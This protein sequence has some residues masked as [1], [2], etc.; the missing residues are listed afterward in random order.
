MQFQLERDRQQ[1]SHT[2][3]DP[4]TAPKYSGYKVEEPHEEIITRWGP[5]VVTEGNWV[6]T[7]PLGETFGVANEDVE[8]SGVWVEAEEQ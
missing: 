6:F 5:T 2:G 7:D 4:D 1:L 8:N 3:G